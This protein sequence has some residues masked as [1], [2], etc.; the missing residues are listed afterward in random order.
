MLFLP[1]LCGTAAA[2][3]G[4]DGI[5]IVFSFH[6][7]PKTALGQSGRPVFFGSGPGRAALD[8]PG[9]LYYYFRIVLKNERFRNNG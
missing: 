3:A 6:N 8:R 4:A 7:I 2:P 1:I 5:F 9:L